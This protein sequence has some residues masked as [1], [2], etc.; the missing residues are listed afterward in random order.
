MLKLTAE[1]MVA[2]LLIA[3]I[4]GNHSKKEKGV[5]TWVGVARV[6]YFILLALSVVKLINNYPVV[7]VLNI[8]WLVYLIVVYVFLENTFRLKR[9][10]FG[11]PLRATGVTL[12][13]VLA[14][15]IIIIFF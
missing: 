8:L 12:A 10:T 11:N 13:L 5:S 4:C 9:E 2:I 7:L 6:A 14:L 1:A 15:I 3:N